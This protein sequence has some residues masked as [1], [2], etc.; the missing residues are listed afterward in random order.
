MTKVVLRFREAFLQEIGPLRHMLFLAAFDQPF[1]TFWTNVAPGMTLVTAWAGG[2]TAFRLGTTDRD[3]LL[4]LALTSFADALAVPRRIVDEQFL[5]CYYHDWWNDPF[6][7]GAY[8]YVGMGGIDAHRALAEPVEGTLFFAG[9][10]TCGS[11]LNGTMEG[12]VRSGWR[13]ADEVIRTLA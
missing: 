2:P 6:A 9:E 1:L 4:N 11:G 12:A 5:S 13:A 10:A 3:A 7:L 8:T